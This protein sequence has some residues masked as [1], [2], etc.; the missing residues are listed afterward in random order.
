MIPTIISD[1]AVTILL[2]GKPHTIGAS[3]PNYNKVLDA[4]REQRWDDI[5][6]LVDVAQY[7]NTSSDGSIQVRD[8]VVL[9]N[10]RE[11]H[12]S[13]T[14]RLLKNLEQGFDTTPTTRFLENLMLNPSYRAVQ[15]LYTFLEKN[16]LPITEDGHFLAYKRVR[17]NFK[18]IHSGTF[19]N[20][21]GQVVEIPRNEVCEDS[22]Q[23]CSAGL[24]FCSYSYLPHF[25]WSGDSDNVVAVKIN[26]RDVVSF[27]TDYNHAKG[28]C[29]RYE[30]VDVLE[31][32]EECKF[33]EQMDAMLEGIVMDMSNNGGLTSIQASVQTGEQHFGWTADEIVQR[34]I[35]GALPPADPDENH[36]WIDTFSGQEIPYT[37]IGGEWVV[38]Y[39]LQDEIDS[40]EDY[41]NGETDWDYDANETWEEND[42]WTKKDDNSNRW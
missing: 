17:N 28:R 27:P 22:E 1:D 5:E 3:H 21:V 33:D 30:V 36:L 31:L 29:C 4:I 38:D 41:D 24:H 35:A 20:S 42:E 11:L 37:F 14:T 39:E 13:V 16:E 23:T 9:Y 19:S 10:G 15:E 7:I 18:D 26:P 40:V 6:H 8:G 12:N 32:P 25:G 2:S 34:L